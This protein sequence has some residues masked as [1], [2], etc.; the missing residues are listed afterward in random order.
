[1]ERLIDQV[2]QLCPHA[3]IDIKEMTEGTDNDDIYIRCPRMQEK[4]ANGIYCIVETMQHGVNTP[5][6]IRAHCP[7]KD[8]AKRII[9]N[10]KCGKEMQ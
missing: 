2:R 7:D 10:L 6:M 9:S 4:L 1:M 5:T 8:I 3:Y